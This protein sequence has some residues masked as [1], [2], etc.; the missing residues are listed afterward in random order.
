MRSVYV[1]TQIK[2]SQD[3]VVNTHKAVEMEQLIQ[4][5]GMSVEQNEHHLYNKR[6][7]VFPPSLVLHFGAGCNDLFI[8]LANALCLDTTHN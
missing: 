2:F 3:S 1:P 6:Y 8:I 4:Q 5:N 7:L